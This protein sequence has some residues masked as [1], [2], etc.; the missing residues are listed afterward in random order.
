MEL[1]QKKR[2]EIPA[3]YKWKPENIFQTDDAWRK[4]ADAVKAGLDMSSPA[5]V[6]NTMQVFERLV[7]ELEEAL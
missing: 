2:D 6:K 5:P 7:S 3:K 4:A 1:K